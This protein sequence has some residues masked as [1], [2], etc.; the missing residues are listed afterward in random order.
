[1]K[2]YWYIG[3]IHGEISLLDSLLGAILEHD[4]DQIIFLGDYI[5]RGP[6]SKEVVDRILEL[7]VPVTCLMGNHELMMLNA[8]EDSVYGNNPM[9][10]WY[11]NGGESTLVS[12]GFPGFFSFQSQMEKQYLEFFRGLRMNS[13]TESGSEM[14][15]LATH[16]GVTPSIPIAD[17]LLLK[18]YHDLQQYMWDRQLAQD[19][20]F[21]W[22]RESFFTGSSDLWKGY[23][24]I[25]GHTPTLKLRRFV[26]AGDF[27]HFH[28]VDNDLAIRRNGERGEVV[29]VGIDSGSTISGRLTGLGIFMENETVDSD[30]AHM[31]S[32]TATRGEI[33]QRELGPIGL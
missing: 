24:V 28:F 10:Q 30:Q 16:A 27:P 20:S 1:M 31:K 25:H 21:L 23:L 29:S 9:E 18:D 13:V 3:D 19:D 2:N 32:L 8:L 33:L 7:E 14:R 11:R 15:I 26:Q 17:Q 22:A 12:F 6:H 5:D 4:P